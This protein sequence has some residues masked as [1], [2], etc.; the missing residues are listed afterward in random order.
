MKNE[1][2][3]HLGYGGSSL[4]FY[5]A[6]VAPLV[7]YPLS[8]P[9]L[10]SSDSCGRGRQA[11]AHRGCGCCCSLVQI[12]GGELRKSAFVCRA[13]VRRRFSIM[14]V[15]AP[16]WPPH[17]RSRSEL[18]GSP[19]Q[20]VPDCNLTV[21]AGRRQTLPHHIFELLYYCFSSSCCCQ[22]NSR[23]IFPR[24]FWLRQLQEVCLNQWG[25]GSG[26]SAPQTMLAVGW[27]SLG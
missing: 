22:Y 20:H 21:V 23:A 14:C 12:W 25:L 8:V 24:G 9:R 4:L 3:T 19:N 26:E 13:G 15:L 7:G 16:D 5:V 27:T 10:P 18:P 2:H 1:V 11:R 6:L 17:L